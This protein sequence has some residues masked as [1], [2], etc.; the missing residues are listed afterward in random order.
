M[1]RAT[2]VALGSDCGKARTTIC[3]K[4]IIPVVGQRSRFFLSDLQLIV[5]STWSLRF[6]S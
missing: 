3:C 4:E 5:L 6:F 1:R 2:E